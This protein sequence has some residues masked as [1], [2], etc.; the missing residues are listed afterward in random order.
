MDVDDLLKTVKYYKYDHKLKYSTEY[1]Q[2]YI[3]DVIFPRLVDDKPKKNS[4][5]VDRNEEYSF[6]LE[7]CIIKDE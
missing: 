4:K 3:H 2:M 5:R 7:S 1:F 6:V